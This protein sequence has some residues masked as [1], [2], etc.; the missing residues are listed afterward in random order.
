[1]IDGELLGEKD[2]AAVDAPE[3]IPRKDL[4][5]PQW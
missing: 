3:I 2:P 4:L 1:V 5:T